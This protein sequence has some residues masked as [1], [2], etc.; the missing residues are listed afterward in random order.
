[1]TMPA[2]PANKYQK[3]MMFWIAILALTILAYFTGYL[4]STAYAGIAGA[5]AGGFLSGVWLDQH[6]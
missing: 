4:S 1:M 6:Q 3:L 5:A 2:Q